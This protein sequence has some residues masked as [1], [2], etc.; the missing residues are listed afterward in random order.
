MKL[1]DVKKWQESLSIS[2]TL[3]MAKGWVATWISYFIYRQSYRK[4]RNIIIYP[5]V[6]DTWFLSD[7]KIS[8]THTGIR[9]SDSNVYVWPAKTARSVHPTRLGFHKQFC[10]SHTSQVAHQ[11]A[12][13]GIYRS[14]STPPGMGC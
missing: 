6:Y 9:H 3:D 2:K 8:S 4:K 5:T 11:A 13:V 12:P 1:T 7:Q 10:I 14:I